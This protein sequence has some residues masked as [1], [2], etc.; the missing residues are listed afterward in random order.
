MQAPQTVA[1]LASA[2][3]GISDTQKI[4]AIAA[5]TITGNTAR[6]LSKLRPRCP[7]LG[8]SPDPEVVRRMC[9]YYGVRSMQ[10]GLVKHTTDVLKLA[11]EFAVDLGLAGPGDDIIVISGRPLGKTGVTNTLVVHTVG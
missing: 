10:A 8:I 5:F 4:A 3:Q 11:S 7:I 1:S 2:V 9:L 6:I